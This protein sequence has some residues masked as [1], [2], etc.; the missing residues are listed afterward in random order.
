MSIWEF[1]S[2]KIRE[3]KKTALLYVI[4][5]EGSSPGRQGFHMA[6]DESGEMKGSI[7]GGFMEQK[8]VE[9]AKSLLKEGAQRPFIRRQ[10]HRKDAPGNQSGMICSGEQTIAFYFPSGE[11]HPVIH[12]LAGHP[13]GVLSLTERGFSLD[14]QATINSQFSL[15]MLSEQKWNFQEQIGHCKTLYIIGGGHVGLA[16]SE[17][18]SRL[19]FFIVQIDD[20][21]GLNTMQ[22]NPFANVKSI[23]NYEDIG[24]AISE[25]EQ[26]YVVLVSFGYRTD[27]LILQKILKR[28][29]RYLGMMGSDEKVRKLFAELK[30]EGYDQKYLDRVHAPIGIPIHSR[31]PFEIAVSIAAQI[32]SVKNG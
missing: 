15:S 23:I 3:G 2:H 32:I 29:Y 16:L 10:I 9:L 6:V 25:S 30:E 24:E 1:I 14:T 21:E 28:K 22:A 5:S 27:K 8:L 7:G 17:I 31:T 12:H 11:D 20:R 4:T 26:S 19:G 13:E 18:M